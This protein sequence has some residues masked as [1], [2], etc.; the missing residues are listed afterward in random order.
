M[1][2]TQ[3]EGSLD[4]EKGFDLP[5]N[6]LA[7]NILYH[8]TRAVFPCDKCSLLHSLVG[9]E[10]HKTPDHIVT[11]NGKKCYLID[12]KIVEGL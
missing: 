7:G 9:D 6:D 3:C 8:D 12:G 5:I 2:C 11:S 10:V 1:Q 4:I